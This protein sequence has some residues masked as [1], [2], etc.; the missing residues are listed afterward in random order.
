MPVKTGINIGASI[1]FGDCSELIYADLMRASTS[2]SGFNTGIGQNGLPLGLA[3]DGSQGVATC[4]VGYNGGG[5]L[6]SGLY[7]LEYDGDG[8]VGLNGGPALP[9]QTGAWGDTDS[10]GGH[11]SQQYQHYDVNF[12]Q[13]FNMRITRSNPSNPVRNITFTIP[14]HEGE[15]FF[16]GFLDNMQH[17]DV[18]RSMDATSTQANF[19][20]EWSEYTARQRDSYCISGGIPWAA[21][22]VLFNRL[23]C[24]GWFCIPAIA[25]LDYVDHMVVEIDD[26]LD[27]DLPVYIEYGNEVW[28]SGKAMYSRM[29]AEH[30]NGNDPDPNKPAT[31]AWEYIAYRDGLRTNRFKQKMFEKN[32]DR[33]VIIT[34]CRQSA[35]PATITTAIDQYALSGF[36]YDALGSAPYWLIQNG[37]DLNAVTAQYQSDPSGAVTTVL[38][39]LALGKAVAR[40]EVD[41]WVGLAAQQGKPLCFYEVGQSLIPP[42]IPGNGINQASLP[43]LRDCNL[44]DRMEAMYDDWQDGLPQDMEGPNCWY[45]SAGPFNS[46]GEW[47]HKEFTSQSPSIAKKWR[48][49]TRSFSGPSPLSAGFVSATPVNSTSIRVSFGNPSG[50]TSPYLKQLY[51]GGSPISGATTSPYTDTGLAPSTAYQYSAHYSD[52]A[53]PTPG[54]AT[55]A[56]ATATT[57]A[58]DP[59]P[60]PTPT[61][62]GLPL[63]SI[64]L[65]RRRFRA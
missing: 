64:P 3:A 27:P 7:T 62:G 24:A 50:G 15:T 41:Y 65:F 10:A 29:L 21:L 32:P 9:G 38:E 49:I 42:T 28:D 56:T 58:D 16:Q 35:Y 53:T 8:T 54:T 51:R 17:W 52:S 4:A 6:V 11:I 36:T 61:S 59:D 40:A 57:P 45:N 43:M 26:T 48:S 2:W 33:V 1:T 46:F 23:R 13:Q 30:D 44:D 19:E 63:S 37:L 5:N 18:L 12:S 20:S 39:N 60:D 34:L 47:G 22:C 14:G 25:S 31:G 55:S